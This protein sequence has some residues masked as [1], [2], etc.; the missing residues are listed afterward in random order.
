MR[1]LNFKASNNPKR[2]DMT[3]KSVSQPYRSVYLATF[4]DQNFILILGGRTIRKMK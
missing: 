4:R 1:F 2:V 3:L